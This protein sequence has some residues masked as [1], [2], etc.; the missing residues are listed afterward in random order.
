MVVVHAQDVDGR[1]DHVEVAVADD[2]L[3]RPALPV[4]VG[5]VLEQV[6]GIA[7]A[8][9]RVEEEP[10]VQRVDA[11]R[12]VDVDRVVGVAGVGHGEVEAHP[13]T[14]V[15]AAAPQLVGHHPVAEE[16]V[17]GRD[18]PGHAVLPARRVVAR[19]VAEERGAERLVEG[20]PRGHPVAQDV[21]HREG[22]VD[23][24]VG[25]VAVGPAARVLE[26]PGAGP[27][28]RASATARCRGRAA[29]RRA[30]RRTPVRPRWPDRRPGAPAA[31]PPRSGTT[32]RRGRR[33]G[34]RRP[35]S[36]GSGRRRPRRCPRPARRRGS[37]RRCPRW[38]ACVRPRR[39]PPRSGRTRWPCPT[40]SRT[41]SAR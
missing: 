27:S 37:G 5:G 10:V 35:A 36:G 6:G 14:Y 25:G 18:E 33:G 26:R 13:E 32:W 17:V 3:P 31:T 28:G 11:P 24:A 38:R 7:A 22:V 12:G 15:V 19:G 39:R 8:E 1:G 20:R 2:A 9:D 40:R 23:E 41:G 34:P 30:G 21:V 4:E 29:R 16:E